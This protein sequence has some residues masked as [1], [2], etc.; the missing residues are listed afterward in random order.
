MGSK[1][2]VPEES[3]VVPL[4]EALVRREGG[5]CYRGCHR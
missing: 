3:Y 4:G 2:H 1:G 5:R